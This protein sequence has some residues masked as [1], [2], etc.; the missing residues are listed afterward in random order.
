MRPALPIFVAA[1]CGVLFVGA[2]STTQDEPPSVDASAPPS[3]VD[4]AAP[5]PDAAP[6]TCDIVDIPEGKGRL[7]CE[8][9]G[10]DAPDVTVP[11]EFCVRELTTT[12]VLEARVMTFAP[13]GDLFLTAPSQSTV[14]GAHGGPGGIFVLPDDDG[15]GKADAVLPFAGTW[16]SDGR[17]CAAHGAPR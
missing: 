17:P 16:P 14:G 11:P 15:D 12:P 3:R 1:M 5:S 7:F 6:P 2:C 13:N 9:P 4:G 10:A 8:L